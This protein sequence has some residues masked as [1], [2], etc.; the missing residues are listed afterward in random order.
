MNGNTPK[1]AREILFEKARLQGSKAATLEGAL[2]YL[3]QHLP[4]SLPGLR[5]LRDP[6]APRA[7][8]AERYPSADAYRTQKHAERADVFARK[9]AATLFGRLGSYSAIASLFAHLPSNV[10]ARI[11]DQLDKLW[12]AHLN[13]LIS[14]PWPYRRAQSSWA[15]GK[16][17]VYTSVSDEAHAEGWTERVWSSNGKW[18]GNNSH[19]ALHFTRRCIDQMGDRVIVGT[20]VTLDCELVGPRTYQATWAEQSRGVDLKMVSGWLVRGYHSTASSLKRALSATAKARAEA[21]AVLA[22]QRNEVDSAWLKSVYVTADDSTRAGNCAPGTR[23]FIE[24]HDLAALHPRGI[25]ADALLA[26]EDSAFT[27]RAIAHAAPRYAGDRCSTKEA[28]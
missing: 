1:T 23:N 18:S 21:A 17:F 28:L 27:R 10:Q 13:T 22:M 11:A 14:K 12:A 3:R 19:C 24:K 7:S 15:G 20:L 16:H 9:Q 8:S 25:R 6:D 26:L 2:R 5:R 4:E